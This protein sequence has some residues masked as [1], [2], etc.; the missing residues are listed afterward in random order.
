MGFT[1]VCVLF[2]W[3]NQDISGVRRGD[4]IILM[5][6]L[7]WASRMVYM[8]RIIDGFETF[9]LVFYPMIFSVPVFFIQAYFWDGPM[10]FKADMDVI[11]ALLYQG[12]VTSSFGFLVWTAL[13]KKYG[14]SSLH[15]FIFIMP[16]SGVFSAWVLLGEPLTLNLLFAMLL[17][18]TGILVVHL[19]VDRLTAIFPL[20]RNI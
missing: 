4:L 18:V 17:I 5:A 19:R 13:L 1:G 9:H 20:G 10:I 7:V 12:L 6:V 11:A 16:V 15:A 3:K 2:L 14:A 8:K